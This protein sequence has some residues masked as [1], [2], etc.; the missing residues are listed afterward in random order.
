MDGVVA[1]AFARRRPS[2]DKRAPRNGDVPGLDR[3]SKS[4]L[5]QGGLLIFVFIVC[6]FHFQPTFA[7]AVIPAAKSCP[8]LDVACVSISDDTNTV[9]G[10]VA[11][12][13]TSD[14]FNSIDFV[15]S[16][17]ISVISAGDVNGPFNH[18]VGMEFDARTN[19][20]FVSPNDMR[21]YGS[22]ESIR[23]ASIDISEVNA[24]VGGAA[25][26]RLGLHSVDYD[27]GAMRSGEFLPRQVRGLFS[28]RDASLQLNALPAKYEQ[29][30]EADSEQQ[31][32][33][34]D[35]PNIVGV[36]LFFLSAIC[37]GFFGSLWGWDNFYNGR[38]LLGAALICGS[39]LLGGLGFI[40]WWSAML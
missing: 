6:V 33:K 25:V 15:G 27:F 30:K 13:T 32:R 9:G 23:V 8:P 16:N 38:R 11:I 36:F 35:K 39:G 18:V 14:K 22:D 24:S 28:G 26:T 21:G 20:A 37:F 2:A 1:S 3:S 7:L 19:H 4:F 34:Y 40:A 12:P 5:R 31:P 10:V 17:R 29:L